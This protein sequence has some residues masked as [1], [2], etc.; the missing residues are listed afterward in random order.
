M[1]QN[2]SLFPANLVASAKKTKLTQH[3]KIYKT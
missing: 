2:R 1:T 3:K